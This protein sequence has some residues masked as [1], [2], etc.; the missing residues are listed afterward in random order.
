MTT[1]NAQQDEVPFLSAMER[2]PNHETRVTV[3]ARDLF[4]GDGM[5][6]ALLDKIRRAL[7]MA[8]LPDQG[9]VDYAKDDFERGVRVGRAFNPPNNGDADSNWKTI[10]LFVMGFLQALILAFM[11]YIYST[12][13]QTHDDVIRIKCRLDPQSCMGSTNVR[14]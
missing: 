11:G 4:R 9:P 7:G 3:N 2:E 14:P 6:W 10:A 1:T 12:T 5:M 8:S 13:S